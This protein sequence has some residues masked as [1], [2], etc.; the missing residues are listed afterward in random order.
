MSE[1]DLF[2]AALQIHDLVER[3]AWLDRE[4]AGNP[5]LRQ[6]IDVLLQALAQ[7]GDLLEKPCFALPTTIGPEGP[8]DA[9]PGLAGGPTSARPGRM[10]GPYKVLEPIGEGG[11]GIVF[12]AEQTHPVRRRVALKV[13]KPGLDTRQVVARFEAERQALA[14]MDHPNIAHVFDGGETADGRPYFVMELVKGIPITDYCDQ[15]QLPPRER[16][17]L[18][19]HV[20]QAVQHAHQKGIIHRDLKPS[21]ILVT[22]HDGTPGVKVIDFGIAKATGQ[23]LTE[24]T[25]FSNFAQ[26]IGTPLYMSPEQ[27]ALSGLDVD[28]RSDIYS[29]GVVLYELL[30]GTTPLTRE[31]LKDSNYDQI[32]RIIGEEDPPRPSTRISTLGAAVAGTLSAQRRSAPRQL[33]QLCRGELDWIVMKCLEKDRNRRYETAIN[34]SRDVERYLHDEP[35]QA[36]PPSLLYRFG[37]FARRY[38]GTLL[39][40][41]LLIAVVFAGTATSVW[42]AF[43]ATRAE[44]LAAKRLVAE[45][46]ARITADNAL[47]QAQQRLFDAKLAQARASRLSR[48]VGQRFESLAALSEATQLAES[49]RQDANALVPLRTEAMASLALADIRL[50]GKEWPGYPNGTEGEVAFDAGLERYAR[51]DARGNISVRR[52]ADDRELAHLAGGPKGVCVM[53]FSPDGLFLAVQ[54]WLDLAV[55]PTNFQVWDWQRGVVRFQVRTPVCNLAWCLGPDGRELALGHP[56]HTVTIR[57]TVGGK[58]LKRLQVGFTPAALAYHPD[59]SKLAVSGVTQSDVMILDLASR[60]VL[61]LLHHPGTTADR[62]AW[63]PDGVL[64]ATGGNDF[65][66]YLW[67][68]ATG[69]Q[70]AVLA[71]H[72]NNGIRLAFAPGGDVLL[73][74]AWDDTARLWNPWTGR[75]LLSFAANDCRFSADGGRLGIHNGVSLGVWELASGR[76]YRTL[77]V[78]ATSPLMGWGS[79]S[80]DGRW[81]AYGTRDGVQLWDLP[82]R[83]LGGLLPSGLTGGTVFHP[84]KQELFTIGSGGVFRWPYWIEGGTLHVGPAAKLLAT[85]STS[86]IAVSGDGRLLALASYP[87]PQ[88]L[89]LDFPARAPLRCDHLLNYSVAFHPDGRWLASGQHNGFGVKVWDGRTGRCVRDLLPEERAARVVFSPDGHWLVTCTSQEFAFWQVDTWQ[90]V[91]S[92]PRERGGQNPGAM[93]FCPRQ[94]MLALA[95]SRGVTRLVHPPTGRELATLREP[96]GDEADRLHFTPD[97]SQLVAHTSSPNRLQVWDLRLIRAQLKAIGLDWDLT[98]GEVAP[99]PRAEQ[100]VRLVVE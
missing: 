19:L 76:E 36:C 48:Q 66:I 7:A 91:R 51:G 13:L 28:T 94:G 89:D 42:L 35:V 25:L 31:R 79:M 8:T 18:F 29:L 14:L 61:F 17:E 100:P 38:R 3:A 16:L 95:V 83:R 44:G 80:G 45:T 33:I 30:T 75:Q 74:C 81:V 90:C 60:K 23:Q 21:N 12:L 32:R 55:S 34:L 77:A 72:H 69:R 5:A 64:L 15:D 27:A 43:R 50:L 53:R 58:E 20:C 26:M 6:R 68:P 67:D 59:G 46:E 97:G 82:L 99:S 98:S 85:T 63:H 24:K 70:H 37:K 96:E 65:R 22:L 78:P 10:I 52:V 54:S 84:R 93:A 57:E 86:E 39:A 47:R 92:T 87:G 73:S 49:L 41:V 40:A 56:D 62:L 88:V 71:G 1:R 9:A 4:C 2:S 11:F